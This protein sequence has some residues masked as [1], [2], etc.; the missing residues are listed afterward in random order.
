MSCCALEKQEQ[1]NNDSAKMDLIFMTAEL[2]NNLNNSADANNQNEK[3][4]GR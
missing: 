4:I 3:S 1:V 2:N